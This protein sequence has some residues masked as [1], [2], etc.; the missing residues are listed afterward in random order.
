MSKHSKRNRSATRSPLIIGL[1]AVAAVT[2]LWQYAQ[3]ADG[4]ESKVTPAGTQT[5]EATQTNTMAA[6]QGQLL[7]RPSRNNLNKLD[8][9]PGLHSLNLGNKRDGLIYIPRCY[10]PEKPAP[11]ALVLHGAGGNAQN[12][13][14]PLRDLADDAG[15]LLLSVDSRGRTWDVIL[16]QYGPDVAFIDRALQQVFAQ[17][18]VDP[19]RIAISGFSDGASYALSLGIANG[20]LFRHIVAF[21]PGFMA[22]ARQEGN[23]RVFVSHGTKDKVLP[24]DPCSRRIVPS[25]K[26]AGYAVTYDEFNGPHTLPAEIARQAIRWLDG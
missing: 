17:Y 26:R 14:N 12:G 13:L 21:S 11:L 15:L 6:Q 22:P 1:I 2:G 16:G 3:D 5:T 7:A 18:A 4:K 20:D 24:I 8:G 23:P 10:K 25:L 9:K 19:Q